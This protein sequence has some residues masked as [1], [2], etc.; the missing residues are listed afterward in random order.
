MKI[1]LTVFDKTQGVGVGWGWVGGGER[2]HT[3]THTHTHKHTHARTNDPRG[4]SIW[5]YDLTRSSGL[6]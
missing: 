4:T 2:E 6:E 1:W 3:H 5:K